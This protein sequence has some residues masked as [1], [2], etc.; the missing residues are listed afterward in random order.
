MSCGS[1]QY[2]NLS[3]SAESKILCL[4]TLFAVTQYVTAILL[5][6]VETY[7]IRKNLNL[8]SNWMYNIRMEVD[9]SRPETT[10]VIGFYPLRVYIFGHL[11]ER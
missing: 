7:R 3:V 5:A 6:S 9:L 11:I 2:S 4:S 10:Q 8:Q 1:G